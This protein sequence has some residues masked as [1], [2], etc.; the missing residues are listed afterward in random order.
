MARPAKPSSIIAQLEGS[1]TLGEVA[2]GVTVSV[3]GSLSIPV[4]EVKNPPPPAVTSYPNSIVEPVEKF[5][6]EAGLNIKAFSGEIVSSPKSPRLRT[7]FS[8]S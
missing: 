2:F 7:R 4:T 3:I 1:G 6:F 8:V 5:G